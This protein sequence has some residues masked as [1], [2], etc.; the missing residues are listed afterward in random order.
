MR[1]AAFAA[2]LACTLMYAWGMWYERSL[3]R[4]DPAGY[5]NVKACFRLDPGVVEADLLRAFG[6]PLDVAEAESMRR[7][8][9][10]SPAGATAPIRAEVDAATGRVIELRCR[11]DERP[12]WVSAP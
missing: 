12:T 6:E 10:R 9:F 8:E 7:L 4:S 11:G 1:K 3:R 2:I 5:R